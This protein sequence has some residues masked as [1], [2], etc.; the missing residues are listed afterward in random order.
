M[1]LPMWV[2]GKVHLIGRWKE[3]PRI[4]K[5]HPAR[6]ESDLEFLTLEF[7]AIRLIGAADAFAANKRQELELFRIQ[8]D[9]A[10]G[11]KKIVWEI[12]PEIARDEENEAGVARENKKRTSWRKKTADEV[13]ELKFQIS[14]PRN[15]E[16]V[17]LEVPFGFTW[18]PDKALQ[19]HS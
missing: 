16:E 12:E 18:Y 1:R 3:W 17:G 15:N 10:S 11:E 14:L 9:P 4:R 2:S 6:N 5:E 13:S 7:R 19:P 8:E